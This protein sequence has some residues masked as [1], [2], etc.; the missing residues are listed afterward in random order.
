MTNQNLKEIECTKK[1]YLETLVP[2]SYQQIFASFS[3]MTFILGYPW[4]YSPG[5]L[6]HLMNIK[7][8]FLLVQG[9][10]AS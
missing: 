2:A 9:Q 10:Q 4:L 5:L 6:A 7:I 3:R 1:I 8:I